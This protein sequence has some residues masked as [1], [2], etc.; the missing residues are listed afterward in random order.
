MRIKIEFSQQNN[1]FVIKFFFNC[2]ICSASIE[3]ITIESYYKNNEALLRFTIALNAICFPHNM[4]NNFFPIT[5]TNYNEYF[6]FL[7]AFGMKLY[8]WFNLKWLMTLSMSGVYTICTN[9][10]SFKFNWFTR[11]FSL[12]IPMNF[13]FFKHC[14][15]YAPQYNYQLYQNTP[16]IYG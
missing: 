14:F 12:H 8:V 1:C 15:L 6:I 16:T 7:F 13:S 9:A 5:I 11:H 3:L 4:H 10:T 2:V